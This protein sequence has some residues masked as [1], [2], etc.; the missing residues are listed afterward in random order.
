MNAIV[1]PAYKPS[2]RMIPF[3]EELSHTFASIV[4]VDDGG[5]AEYAHIFQKLKD[6][7]GVEVLVHEENRGKGR[8]LKTAFSYVMSRPEITGVITVDADGQH[9]V[10]DICKVSE[11]LDAN[12]NSLVLGCRQFSDSSIP[13]RSRFG[14]N[15]SRVMYRVLCG[16]AVSDTQTGLRGLPV[17]FL[18]TCI[19][20]EGERYEYETNML[21]AA[22]KAGVAFA[23]VPITTVYEDNNSSSHFH[24]VLDSIRIYSRLLRYSVASLLSVLMEF[25][26]FTVLVHGGLRIL[27]ATYAARACSCVFNFSL[28]RKLVFKEKGHIGAQFVKYLTLVVVSSTLSGVFVTLLDRLVSGVVVLLK[29]VVDTALY[30]MNYYVQKNWVF[31]KKN[32]KEEI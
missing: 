22:K 2:E 32:K 3:V 16:I 29:M 24:P 23:E 6:I 4:V 9:L 7:S 11:A 30:F 15:V 14:N 8:A 28:N 26:I 17:S 25:L 27:F 10:A 31:R 12:P 1:I 13:A 21:I 5:G 20:A 18:P 19:E